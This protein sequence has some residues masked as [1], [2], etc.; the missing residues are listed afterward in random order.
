[1]RRLALVMKHLTAAYDAVRAAVA[2]TLSLTPSRSSS[3]AAAR[4]VVGSMELPRFRAT[5]CCVRQVHL[6]RALSPAPSLLFATDVRPSLPCRSS[7]L[8][9]VVPLTPSILSPWARLEPLGEVV[10]QMLRDNINQVILVQNKH[11]ENGRRDEPLARTLSAEAE[12]RLLPTM[13]AAPG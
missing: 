11:K 4:E 3:E 10:A 5:V 8:E 9:L 13:S 2:R 6:R 7:S 1:M 12:Q